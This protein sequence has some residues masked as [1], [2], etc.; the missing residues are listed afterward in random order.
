MTDRQTTRRRVTP[1]GGA[2]VERSITLT[3]GIVA[4]AMTLL[5]LPLVDVTVDIDPDRIG[6][7]LA[8]HSD[9]FLSF[10]ISF[11]VTYLFWSAHAAAVRSVADKGIDLP[12]INIL[13]MTWL[14]A[15]AFL[16]FP[17]AIVGRHLNTV[18]APIY[19]GT[20][21]LVSVLTALIGTL[22]SRA[23]PSTFRIRLAWTMTAILAFSTVLSMLDADIGMYTLLLLILART[24]DSTVA[25]RRSPSG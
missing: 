7:S 20:L 1:L 11:V 17:T 9:L 4:I 6:A 3:D 23:A 16:P 5:V 10:A 24:I 22:S 18:S 25:R 12:S 21:L 2:G 19:I 8:A 14:L 13:T 15:I